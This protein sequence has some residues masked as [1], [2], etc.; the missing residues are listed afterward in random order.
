MNAISLPARVCL[1]AG[2]MVTQ[3]IGWGT[4]YSQASILATPIVNEIGLTRSQVFLGV[5]LLF[6]CAAFTAAPAGKLADRLGGL[7]LLIPGTIVLAGALWVLSNAQGLISYLWPWALIGLVFHIG[8]VTTAYTG[9]TQVLG[10]QASWAIATLTLATGLCSAIFW[11]LSEWLLGSTDWRGVLRIY[12]ALTL[13][14]ALPIHIA[15]WGAFGR[16]RAG[17]SEDGPPA[18]LPHVRAGQERPAQ[19]L[20]ISITSIGS[21]IGVGFGVAA[22]EVFTIL[23]TPRDEAVYAGALMG[24]AYVISRAAW[25]LLERRLTPVQAASITYA[26]LPLSLCPLLLFSLTGAPL[27]GWVAACVAFGFGLPAGLVGLLR[28]LLPLYLFGSEGYGARFG[29]QARATEFSSAIAPFGFSWVLGLSATGL[30]GGLVAT[31][32]LAFWGTARLARLIRP[33]R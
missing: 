16:L 26:A 8:L 3:T 31:S 9:L 15:L 30:L 17:T 18:A 28:S 25:I 19:R 4:T 2:L 22:I 24:L 23:G 1:I 12:A 7:L 10:R 13:L 33:F 5:T 27:P 32:A 21:L 14:G 29:V 6:V 20:M 11:P